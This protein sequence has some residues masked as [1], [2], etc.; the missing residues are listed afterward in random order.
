M[1]QNRENDCKAADFL[2]SV[3]RLQACWRTSASWCPVVSGKQCCKLPRGRYAVE[4]AQGEIPQMPY[5]KKCLLGPIAITNTSRFSRLSQGP[6]ALALEH[7]LAF[8]KVPY[9][10]NLEGGGAGSER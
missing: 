2:T 7:F 8:Y 5:S 3:E 10:S 6:A 1:R 4:A 9:L